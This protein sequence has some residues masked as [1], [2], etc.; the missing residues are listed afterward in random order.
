MSMKRKIAAILAADIAGY[1]RLIA[2]DE[3]ATVAR[4]KE[5]RVVFD[6][7]IAHYGGRIFNTAGDAVMAEFPSAVEAVRCAVDTQEALRTR[8]RELPQ[9][10]RMHF[11]IGISI[12]DV[13]ENGTDLLGDGVNIAARLEGLAKPGGIC[14]ARSV[15]EQVSNKVSIK[16]SDIGEQR[17]KNIP[18]PVHAYVVGEDGA[19]FTPIAGE[20]T[21]KPRISGLLLVGTTAA[22]VASGVSVAL[23]MRASG[24][25]PDA[26][27]PQPRTVAQYDGF[28][29][30]DPLPWARAYRGQAT[31]TVANGVAE[32][33]RRIYTL[34][35]A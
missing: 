12:G 15:F 34:D 23:I 13:I 28:M 27:A 5:Y 26:A 29:A 30:C 32:F 33:T 31:L 2:E 35:G 22:I 11:R 4:L 25:P 19:A 16:F 21:A 3:E 17:V 9:D 8:N 1:S 14:V 24:P 7:L 10:Q 20:P 6:A 18:T